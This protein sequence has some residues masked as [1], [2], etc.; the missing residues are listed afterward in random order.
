MMIR[1]KVLS[2]FASWDL[3]S[4]NGEDNSNAHARSSPQVHALAR[5]FPQ[6]CIVIHSAMQQ[7]VRI[8][9]PAMEKLYQSLNNEQKARFNALDWALRQRTRKKREGEWCAH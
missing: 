5:F 8:V 1:S 4:T 7:A 3:Q 2:N 9:R 6:P